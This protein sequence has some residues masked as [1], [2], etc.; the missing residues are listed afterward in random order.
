MITPRICF[1]VMV[2]SLA[3]VS[4]ARAETH[5][6]AADHNTGKIIKFKEDGTLLWDFPNRNAH[7]VQLLANGNVLINPGSV[8]EVTPQK[9][10]VWEVGQPTVMHAESCQRLPDGNTMIADNGAHTIVDVTPDKKVVWKYD[11]PGQANMRQV[12]RL[13]NGNTLIC[14]SSS[15][16]VLEVNR[17]QVIVWKYELPFPY[18]AQRLD[19]GDTLI[20]SGDGAGK[21]GFYLIQVDKDGRTVWQYGGKNAPHEEQLNWPSGFSRQSDGTIYVSE[22][23]SAVIRVISPDRKTF[24][25]IK[26]PAMKHAA[27]IVVVDE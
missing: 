6:Y 14:A 2:F 9:K 19:N 3:A 16:V 17:E 11:V 15:H 8:Q 18:L 26:S 13:S 20:S 23:Q 21:R 27:T 12:R 7:D 4:T 24:R 22:C 25:I 5:I 1:S 10:I